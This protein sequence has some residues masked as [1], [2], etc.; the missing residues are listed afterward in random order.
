[1]YLKKSVWLSAIFSQGLFLFSLPFLYPLF[2]YLHPIVIVVMWVCMTSFVTFLVFLWNKTVIPIPYSLFATLLSLYAICLLV[3]LFFRPSNQSYESW[4]LIPFQTIGYY[5][6][7]D[8]SPFIAFYN[9]AANVGLFLP[10]GFFIR[11]VNKN[12]FLSFFSSVCSILAIEVMQ[13]LTHRGSFDVDDILLNVL[14]IYVGVLLFPLFHKVIRI[15][16]KG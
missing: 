4:N 8:V 3:L 16:K 15:Q 7:G 5:V 12:R 10:F 9:L 1:M 6:S 2:L 13:H 11:I 14:G